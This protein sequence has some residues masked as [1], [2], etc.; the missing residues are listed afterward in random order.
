M[1]VISAGPGFYARMTGPDLRFRDCFI[2]EAIRLE[3]LK[4]LQVSTAR[5]VGGIVDL[6][7]GGRTNGVG[8]VTSL[9]PDDKEAD[10]RGSDAGN[11]T[12]L[13]QSLRA[14]L[15]QFLASFF[16]EARDGLIVEPRRNLFVLH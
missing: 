10:I 8:L 5:I 14:D 11:S 3:Q 16:A 1:E 4:C 12:R 2:S 15:F 6:V 7:F 13:A 9:H